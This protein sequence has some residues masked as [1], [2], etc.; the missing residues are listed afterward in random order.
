GSPPFGAV[1]ATDTVSPH[2]SFTVDKDVS[3]AQGA[4]GGDGVRTVVLSAR[5]TTGLSGADI[6][7]THPQVTARVARAILVSGLVASNPADLK[8]SN[9]G[10]SAAPSVDS[11]ST[12][13]AQGDE[14]VLA[15]FGYEDD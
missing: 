1:S 3:N 5:V 6:I 2:N 13:T 12:S 14:L 8:A 9:T 11:G 10:T 15:A 7:I 4:A